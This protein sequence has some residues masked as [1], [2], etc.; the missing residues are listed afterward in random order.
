MFKSSNRK[1]V[2]A[3]GIFAGL[4]VLTAFAV[5]TTITAEPLPKIQI[6]H[7]TQGAP[8]QAPWTIIE[9]SENAWKD[10]N[11]VAHG[12]NHECPA[13]SIGTVDVPFDGVTCGGVVPPD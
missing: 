11:G 8:P 5:S 6:C 13:D 7:C 3:A 12:S 1:K 9:V 2:V 4:L 10:G